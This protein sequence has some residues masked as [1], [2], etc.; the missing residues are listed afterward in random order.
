MRHMRTE[1]PALAPIFRSPRQARLLLWVLTSD[2]QVTAAELARVL[3]A[4]EPTVSREVR[5][6][7]GGDLLPHP[8]EPA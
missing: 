4:P 6:L 2:R 8:P 3:D 1:A 7:L 5:R